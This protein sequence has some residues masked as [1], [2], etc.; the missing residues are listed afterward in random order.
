MRAMRFHGRGQPLSIDEVDRPSPG[1]GEVLVRVAAAGVCGTELHFL[2]GLLEPAKTPIVLGHEVAGTVAES[3]E[4]AEGFEEGD[5]VA[6]H[7]FHPCR[8]CRECRSGR[9]HLCEAPLGFLAFASDGGFAEYVAVPETALAPLPGGLSFEQAAPLCC[10]ATTALHALHVSSLGIGDAAVVYGCGGVGLQLVQVL[11]LAGVRPIAVSRSPEKIALAEELGAEV[12]ID[13]SAGSVAAAVRR[14]TGG[15]GADAVFELVGTRETM[16]EALAALAR[17]GSLVFV[18]Y[19]F[20]RLDLNPLDIVVPE[21][22]ILTSV[23]N[24]YLELVEALDLAARGLI[25]PVLHECAPLAEANRVL[26][27]LRGGRVTGRAV[28]VP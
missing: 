28:L 23:G 3:G 26:E 1:R 20:D 2:D 24:T 5:R 4:E 19:S 6:V 13:A 16:P 21:T 17:G 27:D 14:A 15:R 22:R 8:R 9:E 12:S 25:R 11:R 7:Y 18:G 10:S